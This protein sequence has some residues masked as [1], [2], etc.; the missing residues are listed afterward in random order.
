[1]YQFSENIQRGILY[2]LKNDIDFFL[3]IINL[4]KP[5]YFEYPSHAKMFDTIKSHYSKY[6]SLPND[7]FILEE[8]KK[9]LGPSEKV[10]DYQDELLY[11]N[12]LD[13]SSISNQ[14]FYLDLI[15]D[16]AKKE[17]MKRAVA[18][19]VSLIKEDWL[20]EVEEKVRKALM[21]CRT[22]DVGQDYFSS[23]SSRWKRLEEVS[24]EEKYKTVL[25]ALDT[26]LEGGLGKK[27]LAMVVAPPGVGKS[28]Y[29]VSLLYTSD[30][31]DDS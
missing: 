29:L 16:F 6:H 14:D 22:V 13:T 20:D 7:D 30:A 18:E 24:T 15:E 8:L 25:P 17:A 28:L 26:S 3:Q 4:V 2:L 12:N 1:M 19:S 10:S 31:A 5:D 21:V 9:C 11:V 27:E 23:Y